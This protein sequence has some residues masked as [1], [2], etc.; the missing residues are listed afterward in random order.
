M[1]KQKIFQILLY[2]CQAFMSTFRSSVVEFF[3]SGLCIRPC[4][5]ESGHFWNRIFSV[6]IRVDGALN[7]CDERFQ[8]NAR[9]FGVR[10][11]SFRV[12]ERPIR[13]KQYAVQKISDSSGRIQEE[14]Q[15]T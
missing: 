12:D 1:Y 14:R 2:D 15:Y 10:I 13:L 5:H 11:H 7:R 9:G 3:K 8:N 4:Q 6:R